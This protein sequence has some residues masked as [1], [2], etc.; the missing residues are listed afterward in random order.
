MDY[1]IHLEPPTFLRYSDFIEAVLEAP[2]FD[3]ESE[4]YLVLKIQELLAKN[5]LIFYLVQRE[6]KL[7]PQPVVRIRIRIWS[8]PMIFD[9]P[10]PDPSLNHLF[11]GKLSSF[12]SKYFVKFYSSEGRILFFWGQE[13]FNLGAVLLYCVVSDQLKIQNF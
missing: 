5:T 1:S 13:T 3:L 6:K 10:D 9:L 12:I 7:C 4:K 11:I 2:I 8:D